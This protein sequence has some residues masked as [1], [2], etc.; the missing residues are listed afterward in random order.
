[1]SCILYCKFQHFLLRQPSLHVIIGEIISMV[2]NFAWQV[3]EWLSCGAQVTELAQEVVAHIREVAGADAL[4]GAFNAARQG[5]VAARAQ[6]KRQQAVQVTRY[7]QSI[8]TIVTI[9]TTTA[10][11]WSEVGSLT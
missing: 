5:V 8:L 11:L 10:R 6:R 9:V 1:M 4:L 3:I 7:C 2:L